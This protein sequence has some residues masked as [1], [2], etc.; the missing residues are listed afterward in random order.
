MLHQYNDGS[1][2]I[3][4]SAKELVAIPVWMGNRTLDTVHAE[5]IKK[6][7]GKDIKMLDSNYCIVTYEEMATSGKPVVQRYLIDG[8]H[9]AS[10]VR[11]YYR[12]SIC[13]PDFIVTVREKHLDSESDAIEYFNIINNV[14]QQSWNVDP[15]LIINK[16]IQALEKKFNTNKKCL[17]IRPN[18]HRPYLSSENVRN[19]LKKYSHLLKNTGESID[20]FVEATVATNTSLI[21]ALE[22]NT[23]TA[24]KNKIMM[25]KAIA[26]KFA[27]A[28]DSDLPWIKRILQGLVL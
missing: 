23:L 17:L 19:S 15:N 14:K 12:D 11:D 20:K 25:D 8:Q 16:Y 1:K 24:N 4:L 21:N 28:Y 9:R 7:V 3:A 2:L 6:A 27:L 26:V 13:E 10:V 18:A 5:S 22:I